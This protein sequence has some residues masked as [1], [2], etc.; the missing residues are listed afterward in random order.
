MIY[1]LRHGDAEPDQGAGD[2]A[3]R[4]TG[5]GRAQ[6][7]AAGKAMA[8]LGLVPDCCLTSPKVRAMETARL[9]C[10]E[11][12]IE[13]ETEETIRDARIRIFLESP[14]TGVLGGFSTRHLDFRFDLTPPSTVVAVEIP[15]LPLLIG[16]YTMNAA[17]YGPEIS[18]FLDRRRRVLLHDL[19]LR[20]VLR[21]NR[22]P[23]M[24]GH[25]ETEPSRRVC[26][27]EGRRALA[28]RSDSPPGAQANTS[29]GP[30]A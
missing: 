27:E 7:E 15:D 23:G 16:G 9:A 2:A 20:R 29:E 6:A 30:G 12:G 4:L 13:I 3:R 18:D 10:A 19:G 8:R 11:L 5:K 24:V 28:G 25:R 22:V 21:R 26:I 17:L 1:L 14:R